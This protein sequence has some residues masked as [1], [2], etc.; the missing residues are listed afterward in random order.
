M[1][2]YADRQIFAHFAAKPVGKAARS[3]LVVS[4]YAK[5]GKRRIYARAAHVTPVF[6]TG[7]R[8]PNGT[9]SLFG[10]LDPDDAF[11]LV[12]TDEAQRVKLA[13]Q[14]KNGSI[15]ERHGLRQTFNLSF[16]PI[17][18]PRKEGA[19]ILDPAP[20]RQSEDRGALGMANL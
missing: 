6:K 11:M 8:R 16:E 5:F 18:M 20:I 3:V 2:F 4:A 15:D 9:G 14:G 7:D 12:R 10:A 19:G 17:G 1:F 13:P